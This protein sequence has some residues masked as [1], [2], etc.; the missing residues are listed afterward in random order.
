M[1]C[2]IEFDSGL[3]Y[4]NAEEFW[5]LVSDEVNNSCNGCYFRPTERLTELVGEYDSDYWEW[6]SYCGERV[7]KRVYL[8]VYSFDQ[9]LR[10]LGYNIG[11]NENG[12]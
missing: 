1:E 7:E 3:D 9:V 5:E 2:D 8:W 12:N 6:L 10:Q 11:G 4:G